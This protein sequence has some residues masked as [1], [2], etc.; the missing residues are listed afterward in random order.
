MPLSP[1][2]QQLLEKLVIRAV[3]AGMSTK[4]EIARITTLG[5]NTV[6]TTIRRLIAR[7]E[8]VERE[9]RLSIPT[10]KDRLQN[11]FG[12]LES[13]L[14]KKNQIKVEEVFG[15]DELSASLVYHTYKR[16]LPKSGMIRL[17]EKDSGIDLEVT[18]YYKTGV[19]IHLEVSEN[20][21][22]RSTLVKV[23]MNWAYTRN[24]NRE[25]AKQ[26]LE[27]SVGRVLKRN[28]ERTSFISL[29]ARYLTNHTRDRNLLYTAISL[30]FNIENYVFDISPT[31][32]KLPEDYVK[33]L[34]EFFDRERI[35][36]KYLQGGK[37]RSEVIQKLN[38]WKE[39]V[40]RKVD[41]LLSV[42]VALEYS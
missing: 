15:S 9:G 1:E 33:P 3:K 2:K 24:F 20:Y 37:Q 25:T 16:H 17:E 36:E 19:Q 21:E 40:E 5:E 28:R 6:Y 38:E 35:K 30:A 8:L 12:K 23:T 22:E 14:F 29:Y 41:R 42:G 18:L 26:Y 39:Y 4:E 7:G 32:E 10:T 31:I 34:W 11:L 13:L 27:K